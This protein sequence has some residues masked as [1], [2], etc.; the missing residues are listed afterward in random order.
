MGSLIL[1]TGGARSGKTRFALRLADRL[2][3]P[4][5]YVATAEAG[6]E[7]MASRIARHRA[8]R[9]P[10]WH[11]LELPLGLDTHIAVSSNDGDTVLI[12]CLS[13]WLSNELLAGHDWSDAGDTSSAV[14]TASVSREAEERL[15]SMVGRFAQFGTERAGVTIVVTNEVGSGIVPAFPLGRLYRDILGRANQ[16]VAA[17]AAAVYLVVAGIGVDLRRLEAGLAD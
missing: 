6:D 4:R 8:E 3:A 2:P 5:I 9:A 7:E 11:T 1:V 16:L 12:D 13:V 17:R 15:M 10:S 14:L